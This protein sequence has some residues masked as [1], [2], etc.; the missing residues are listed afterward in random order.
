MT[1]ANPALA[2][3]LHWPVI[4]WLSAVHLMAGIAVGYVCLIRYSVATLVL[5]VI[6]FFAFH[7]SIR[8][9]AHSL[10]AHK[11]YKAAKWLQVVVILLFSAV[12]Q[13]S[14][15]WWAG[16]HR[17]HHT[18]SDTARDPYSIIHGFSW[19]HTGWVL[20][21]PLIPEPSEVRDLMRNRIVMFQHKYYLP[22]GVAM[23]FILPT[24]V[25]FLWGDPVGGFLVG[26]FLRLCIQF[27]AT[28][29]INSVAHW[30]GERRY[31]KA[32]SAFTNRWF[33]A[34][35]TV[36]ESHHERHHLAETDYRL[37][38]R[39]YDLD[40]GKWVIWSLSLCGATW[41][42][43]RIREEEVVAKGRELSLQCA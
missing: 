31:T 24:A 33:L 28:W 10:Y 30:R 32:G 41:D 22:L 11:A 36:G 9:G 7:L 6:L 12:F 20:R 43:M 14:L 39:W 4:S 26:G 16:L 38:A 42:L 23:G 40:P 5:S 25:A 37:G 21:V 2:R 29:C 18:H 3:P 19:A 35:I 17:R 8:I 27:H 15:L 1:V 13:G 34:V